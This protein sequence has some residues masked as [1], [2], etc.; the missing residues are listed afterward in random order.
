MFVVGENPAL[1]CPVSSLAPQSALVFNV[2]YVQVLG[3]EFDM[4]PCLTDVTLHTKEHMIA[5]LSIL[6]AF[7]KSGTNAGRLSH[8]SRILEHDFVWLCPVIYFK[9][10][11]R[12]FGTTLVRAIS[13]VRSQNF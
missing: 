7:M 13:M 5:C 8:L 11:S 6:R 10:N 4:G 1:G 12:D 3:L 9:R 2:S